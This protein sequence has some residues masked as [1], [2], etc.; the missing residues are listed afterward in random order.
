MRKG[1]FN[2][3]HKSQPI[4]RSMFWANWLMTLGVISI[5]ILCSSIF[6]IGG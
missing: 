3:P 2:E 1:I 5:L 4:A 6:I